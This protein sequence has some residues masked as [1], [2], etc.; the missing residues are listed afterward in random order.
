MQYYLGDYLS[1]DKHLHIVESIMGNTSKESAE[2]LNGV[3][4]GCVQ[5]A[6]KPKPRVYIHYSPGEYTYSEH[7]VNMVAELER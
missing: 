6:S 7:I 4:W 5:T 1:I 2:L 3:M